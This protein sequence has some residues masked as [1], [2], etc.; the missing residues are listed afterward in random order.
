MLV[1]Q[2]GTATNEGSI[3]AVRQGMFARDDGVL[4]N[5]GRVVSGT[6]AIQG[7]ERVRIVN[8]GTVSGMTGILAVGDGFVENRGFVEGLGGNAFQFLHGSNTLM[9]RSGSVVRGDAAGGSGFD[10]AVLQGGGGYAGAFHHFEG[11]EK[12]G[13]G[14]FVLSGDSSLAGPA[15]VLGG[16]LEIAGRLGSPMLHVRSGILSGTGTVDGPLQNH[17]GGAVR[18]PGVGRSLQV[19]GD[20]TNDAGG[21]LLV[22]LESGGRSGRIAVAGGARLRGGFI[23]AALPEGLLQDGEHWTLLDAAG[24]VSGRFA[25][26]RTTP[27][28]VLSFATRSRGGSLQLVTERLPYAELAGLTPNQTAAAGHLDAWL[29]RA[30]GALANTLAGF[31]FLPEPELNTAI[32][33]LSPEPYDAWRELALAESRALRSALADQLAAARAFP[34]PR[35]A[36]E[37]AAPDDASLPPV[38]AAA[39]GFALGRDVRIWAQG[40]AL[41]GDRDGDL[42]VSELS[43][44]QWGALFGAELPIGERWLLGLHGAVLDGES[45]IGASGGGDTRSQTLGLHGSW[46]SAAGTHVDAILQYG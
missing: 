32:A 46:H 34:F 3:E 43:V 11:L 24:G 5:L 8:G 18:V 33:A 6:V 10:L 37:T 45:D 28:P 20:F 2:R 22:D 13:P 15:S 35:R 1:D 36:S 9:L 12:R 31:D 4:R 30:D 38:S 42:D 26:V 7:A 40:L 39:Q 29:P 44:D 16:E 21:R 19:T 27:S 14:R 23:D 41:R 25:G 17:R